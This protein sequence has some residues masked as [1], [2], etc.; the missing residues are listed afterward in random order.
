MSVITDKVI[1][2]KYSTRCDV[3]FY[4]SILNILYEPKMHTIDTLT[5]VVLRWTHLGA[6]TQLSPDPFSWIHVRKRER[7]RWEWTCIQPLTQH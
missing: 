5:T 4:T 1:P 2:R 7:A 6:T 3:D